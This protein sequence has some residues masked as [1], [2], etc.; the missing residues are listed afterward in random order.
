MTVCVFIIS[1]S[2]GVSFPQHF[3]EWNFRELAAGTEFAQTALTGI[4]LAVSD[5]NGADTADEIF[6]RSGKA[7]CLK[8]PLMPA[9]ITLN[10]TV[11]RQDCL[12]YLME[13]YQG[14]QPVP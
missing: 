7:L 9:M 13:K 8:R 10:E 11:I 5:E 4:P 6:V 12:C 2:A 3:E 1:N 14:L